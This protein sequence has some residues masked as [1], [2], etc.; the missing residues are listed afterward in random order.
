M[1]GRLKDILKAPRDTPRLKKELAEAKERIARQKRRIDRLEKEHEQRRLRT[2]VLQ[3]GDEELLA[4]RPE[5]LVWIFGTGRSGNTWLTAMM[6]SAGHP[7]WT[8]PAI[9]KLF[10]EFYY[11]ARESQR[12]GQ[13]WVLGDRVREVWLGSIR[14]FVLDGASGRFP[15]LSKDDYL[16]IK[17]QPGSVGAPLLSEALPESRMIF[18]VRDPRD[19]VSS[20]LDGSRS[21]GWH[22]A[23]IAKKTPER[24]S[25]FEDPTALVERLSKHYAKN[26]GKAAEAYASHQGPKV[27][28]RYEELRADTLGEMRRIHSELGMEVDEEPLARSVEEHSWENIPEEEKGEGKFRRKAQPGGWREDLTPEQ[29]RMVEEKTRPLLEQ[30]YP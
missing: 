28:V 11:G 5:N 24:V 12:G 15:E 23:N 22:H 8:E 14:R 17:E 1:I 26:V 6:E 20:W 13:K 9:G 7:V 19:V 10:G 3:G 16:V 18:L 2:R 25:D 27:L 30:F 29:A 4:L 21:G